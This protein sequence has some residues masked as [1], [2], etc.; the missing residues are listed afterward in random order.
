M[1]DW[2]NDLAKEEYP[3]K[4]KR[5]AEFIARYVGGRGEKLSAYPL[6][7]SLQALVYLYQL[8][9]MGDFEKLNAKT[10]AVYAAIETHTAQYPI[11]LAA[12]ESVELLSRRNF[13]DEV[14]F[15]DQIVALEAEETKDDPV[16]SAIIELTFPGTQAQ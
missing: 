7:H 2:Q 6:S 3:K 11:L 5:E 14:F 10:K 13:G 12:L 16:G 4:I 8:D 1:R 15:V 9:V